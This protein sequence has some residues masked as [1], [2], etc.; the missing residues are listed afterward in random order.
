MPHHLAEQRF[1][2]REVEINGAFGEPGT[3]G[4]I[5][6]PSAGE[7]AFPELDEGSVENLLR[8]LFGKTTPARFGSGCG[9][10]WSGHWELD[11]LP[12]AADLCY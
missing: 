12:A 10:Q 1:L 11:G 6:E 8:S 7:A 3:L 2:V 4:D 9:L 5:L